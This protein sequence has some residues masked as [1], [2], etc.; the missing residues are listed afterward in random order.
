MVI[1][2]QD[3]IVISWYQDIVAPYNMKQLLRSNKTLMPNLITSTQLSY[4][5]SKP[6]VKKKLQSTYYYHT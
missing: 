5:K 1:V 2:L 6:S 4:L 3:Y